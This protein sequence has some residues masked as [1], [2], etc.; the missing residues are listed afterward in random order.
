MINNLLNKLRKA[1]LS[2]DPVEQDLVGIDISHDYVRTVQLTRVNKSWSLTKLASKS[3]A[4]SGLDAKEVDAEIVRLL[5]NLKLEQKFN[6]TNAAISL[7][8]S[9][10]IVQV[11]QIPYLED[12][13]LNIAVENGSLWENSI[14]LPGDLSEYSIFWQVVKRDA[15]KNRISILFVASRVDEIERYCDLVRQ[16]G[17]DPLIVDV[18]C[19]A[20][21]NILRTYS[22][23]AQPELGVFLEVSGFENYV[24]FIYQDLPFIYDIFVMD[25]D[26]SALKEGGDELTPEVFKRLAAQLRT[27]V[28]SF[29]NQSG[30]PGIESIN[31]VSSLPNF[32]R[33]FQG[34][35]DEVVEFKLEK[36]NPFT[37]LNIQAQVKSRV[38]TEKN[39]SAMTVA[40][41]LATRRLD[42]F[43]YFKFVT[44]VANINLLPGRE[45]IVEKEQAKSELTGNLNKAAW[46][47]S[48]IALICLGLYAYLVTSFP[49]NEEIDQL[50][51]QLTSVQQQATKDK[52]QFEETKH[53][54]DDVGKTNGAMLDL[55]FLQSLPPGVYV[56]DI[57]QKRKDLSEIHLKS[58][59][60]ALVSTFM[61]VMSERYKNVKLMGVESNPTDL[62]QLFKI[63]YQ[64]K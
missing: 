61:G 50:Q 48:G 21:R 10:A 32:D 64:V 8:V 51:N 1:L 13:E 47:S 45:E 14:N 34:L 19:F 9:S 7:P 30:A 11:I 24:V 27:A 54:V 52:Q 31:L 59:D 28:S 42:I 4:S 43:G 20:L 57:Y 5:K 2:S 38:E 63:S 35:K 46:I 44:A 6:T 49:S 62:L 15:E 56:V 17:F 22:D 41:G 36:L 55:A 39:L 40:T 12:K 3:V 33:I 25:S 60:P 53:W 23:L 16:A 58:V 26:V 18:R 37:Q 29:I